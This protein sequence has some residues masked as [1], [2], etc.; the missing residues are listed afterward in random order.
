ME[1]FVGRD[2]TVFPGPS[3]H[4]CSHPLKADNLIILAE[5]DPDAFKKG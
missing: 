3:R 1:A 2:D 5:M 4:Q